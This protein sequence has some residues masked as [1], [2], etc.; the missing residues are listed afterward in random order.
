MQKK[1]FIYL[2]LVLSFVLFTGCSFI[3]NAV[4]AK[5]PDLNK[6]FS[7]EMSI[8]LDD[9]TEIKGT[10]SRYGTNIWEMD[11]TEPETVAGLHLSYNDSGVSVSLG[12]LGFDIPSE[13]INDSAV[14]ELIFNAIDNF[15]S[16]PD[17]VTTET[18][19]GMEYTGNISQ[20]SYVLT[21]DK[22][23][24]ALTGISFPELDLCAEITSFCDTDTE[25]TTTTSE[26][27]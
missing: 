15:A 3:K 20:C 14:F 21:F 18:E 10:M 19:T 16:L 24:M 8:S 27:T 17:A 2:L 26:N 5:A 6:A 12:E 9:S 11:L 13:K 4:T 7:C 1:T 23:T 25:E 22:D